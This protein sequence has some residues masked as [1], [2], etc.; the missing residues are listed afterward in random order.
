M[1]DELRCLEDEDLERLFDMRPTRLGDL[2]RE[3]LVR[4]RGDSLV[5]SRQGAIAVVL[6]V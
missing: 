6:L 3:S 1:S 4:P 2:D 5:R